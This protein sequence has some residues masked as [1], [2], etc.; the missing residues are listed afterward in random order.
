MTL[1]S[2]YKNNTFP[3][4]LVISHNVFCETTNMGKTLKSFF[5]SW[6]KEYLA[7]LYFHAEVPTDNICDKYFRVTDTDMLI[8]VFSHKSHNTIFT[9][10][11]IQY[12]RVSTRIDT[13]FIAKIYQYARKRSPL[14]YFLRNSLWRLGIWNSVEIEN[15]I[16]DFNPEV[17]FFASGDYS[18]SYEVTLSISKRKR[19]PII[20]YCCDDFYLNKRKFMLPIA[21]YNYRRLIKYA[22]LTVEQSYKILTISNKMRVDYRKYFNIPTE[23]IH[24]GTVFNNFS[25]KSRKGIVYLGNLCF[26]R[27]KQLIDIGKVLKQYTNSKLPDHIDVYSSEKNQ[28]ILKHMTK[29]NGILFHGEISGNE[30][31]KIISNSLLVIHTESFKRENINKIMYSIST[32]IAE[33]LASGTCIF[34]YG[35]ENIASIE[36]LREQDAACVVAS[37]KMLDSSL[38]KIII[39]NKNRTRYIKNAKKA[40]KKYHQLDITHRVVMDVIRNAVEHNL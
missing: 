2:N 10:N 33:L 35:P 29:E 16:D 5:S 8:S 20:M 1:S 19:I 6:N 21:A 25:I 27:Y 30:V 32:K 13:G 26:D 36:Y 9:F 40:V 24:T 14:I 15:W 31:N 7:Q 38:R 4:V 12:N 37:P 28:K 17:I 3:R 34:A 11:D 23:T 39:D 22:R 18:F